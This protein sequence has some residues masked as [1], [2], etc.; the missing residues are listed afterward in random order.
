MTPAVRGTRQ[1]R[2]APAMRCALARR[3]PTPLGLTPPALSRSQ[4]RP[5][6][7]TSR[8]TRPLLPICH[9]CPAR[10]H[11]AH[12]ISCSPAVACALADPK[13]RGRG[14]HRGFLRAGP[15]AAYAAS[16]CGPLEPPFLPVSPQRRSQSREKQHFLMP[17]HDVLQSAEGDCLRLPEI[18]CLPGMRMAPPHL[19]VARVHHS[20]YNPI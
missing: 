12:P 8:E 10:A 2:S 15:Q 5:P 4:V 18:A 1:I 3:P 17:V 14:E 6:P 20:H 9:P 19:F 7:S 11:H 16:R 13:Q